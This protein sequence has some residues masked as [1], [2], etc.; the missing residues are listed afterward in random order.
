MVCTIQQSRTIILPYKRVLV[1]HILWTSDS[2][3]Q[4]LKA[5]PLYP[6]RM[7]QRHHRA[8]KDMFVMIGRTKPSVVLHDGMNFTRQYPHRLLTTVIL[9]I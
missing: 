6:N 1:F 5:F 7:P 9:T 8:V 3:V 4:Y 2:L